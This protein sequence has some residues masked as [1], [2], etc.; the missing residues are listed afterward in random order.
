LWHGQ[1][2]IAGANDGDELMRQPR[3]GWD[4]SCGKKA[5]RQEWQT[6]ESC[7]ALSVWNLGTASLDN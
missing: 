7:R 1:I 6:E 4:K 2:P 3:S 5:N